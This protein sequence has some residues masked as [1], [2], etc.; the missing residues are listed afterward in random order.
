MIF[1]NPIGGGDSNMLQVRC[2]SSSMLGRSF[3]RIELPYKGSGGIVYPGKVVY[4]HS[5]ECTFVEGEDGKVRD[6]VLA[7]MQAICNDYTLIGTGDSL[8]K[9]TAYLKLGSTAGGETKK[10]KMIGVWPQALPDES[11]SH[12]VTDELTYSVTW[13]YDRWEDA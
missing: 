8:I 13:A 2:R 12:S 6:A 11:V 10:I 9:S 3:G 5:W 4:S 1:T 7:W